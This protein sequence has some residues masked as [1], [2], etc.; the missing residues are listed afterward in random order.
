ME[1]KEFKYRLD[2]S[3]KKLI[4]FTQSMVT[5]SI[6][7][8]V[9]YLIEP[10]C[11]E[12]SEH[13]NKQE[14]NKLM[15]LNRVE[16]KQFNSQEVSDMLY[17]FGQVPLWINTEVFRSTKN[18]TTIKLI[19]SRRFRNEKDLNYKADEFPPFHPLVSL[20]PWK[21]ESEKFNVNWK[22]QALKRKWFALICKWRY[23][24]DLK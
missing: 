15:E 23:K 20:P 9:K 5:N 18:M 3:T 4:K 7:E 24:Q 19:C 14:L 8:N 12:T 22:H 16:R 6:S 10:N 13:L 21:K 17:E 11:R 2:E 1:Q